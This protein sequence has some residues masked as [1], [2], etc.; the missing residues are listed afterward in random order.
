MTQHKIDTTAVQTPW[1]P[2][3]VHETTEGER[4]IQL[5]SGETV[6]PGDYLYNPTT[7]TSAVVLRT[8][9]GPSQQ[10][11]VIRV[12]NREGSV[13][14][15]ELSG[16]EL[17]S[18]CDESV[19]LQRCLA[20]QKQHVQPGD[21]TVHMMI[22]QVQSLTEPANTQFCLW[23]QEL[24][25]DAMELELPFLPASE[26]DTYVLCDTLADVVQQ[27]K[28]ETQTVCGEFPMLA[29]LTAEHPELEPV[30]E[31]LTDLSESRMKYRFDDDSHTN[32]IE[33][34]SPHAEVNYVAHPT[35][36]T[37]GLPGYQVELRG[38]DRFYFAG[39]MTHPERFDATAFRDLLSVKQL[40]V[41]P[42]R[43]LADS[44][45]QFVPTYI[46]PNREQRDLNHGDLRQLVDRLT[47]N[48]GVYF[49]CLAQQGYVRPLG[50][51]SGSFSIHV[52][53]VVGIGRP[54]LSTDAGPTPFLV[55]L[56]H[57]DEEAVLLEQPLHLTTAVTSDLQ[58]V[59]HILAGTAQGSAVAK[60]I[61]EWRET[62]QL[63]ALCDRVSTKASRRAHGRAC[64]QPHL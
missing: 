39:E 61:A 58:T 7:E 5:Q 14:D 53:R 19:F 36:R 38:G 45:V 8:E 32:N 11:A 3:A 10:T 26:L 17:Q 52:Y 40:V 13:T 18:L 29:Q 57:R 37:V 44:I 35:A 41:F 64:D 24:R 42:P 2:T 22:A 34:T 55:A 49:Q 56:S 28:T 30:V 51:P 62:E 46:F 9:M 15:Q 16:Q 43:D 63:E 6:N 20:Y 33:A 54:F 59:R 21:R 12:N 47:E 27:A 1:F 23:L 60:T 50:D 25:S 31:Q 48:G 4:P